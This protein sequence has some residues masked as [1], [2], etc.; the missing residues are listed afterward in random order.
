MTVIPFSQVTHGTKNCCQC[1]H[2]RTWQQHALGAS[3]TC[4]SRYSPYTS[5]QFNLRRPWLDAVVMVLAV[6][7]A[8][9]VIV[10]LVG[11]SAVAII[12]SSWSRD[13]R[14][15]SSPIVENTVATVAVAAY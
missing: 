2:T 3:E 13:C 9:L 8:V 7:V 15:T 5:H 11:G 10:L 6:A 4:I 1:E 14:V 12:L